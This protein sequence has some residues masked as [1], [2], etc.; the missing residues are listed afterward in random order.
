MQRLLSAASAAA[1]SLVLL[2]AAP[3][4][5]QDQQTLD[6]VMAGMAQLGIETADMELSEDQVLRIQAVLNEP[7]DDSEKTS[8]I[9]TIVAE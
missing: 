8:Q 7:G 2:G 6:A 3:G 9:E 1:L 4:F 5:A